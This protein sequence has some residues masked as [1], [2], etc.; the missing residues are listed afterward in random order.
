MLDDVSGTQ[1]TSGMADVEDT[2]KDFWATRPRRPRRGRKIAGVAAGIARRYRIDPTLVR[3]GFVVAAVYGGTGIALYLLGWLFLPEQDDEVSPIESL[4]GKGRS[5]T[6]S[7]FTILLGIVLVPLLGWFFDGGTFG[8]F[9]A[10]LSLLV[11]G[12]LLY[13]LHQ[14]RGHLTPVRTSPPATQEPPVM[15]VMPAMPMTSAPVSDVRADL[16]HTPPVGAP[17]DAPP[18]V[19]DRTTPPAWDPLGA[20]PFAWDLPEP[21]TPPEPEEPPQPPAK[22]HKSR[23][24][25]MTIGLALVVAAGMSFAMGGWITPQHIV[26]VV[27]AV[28]GLGMVAGAFLRG[29]RGLIALAVPLSVAGLA[30]TVISPGGYHGVGDLTAQPTSLAQLDRE[31]ERS[32]GN[33]TLNLTSLPLSDEVIEV[34]ARAD[35]G[36]V[37]VI[38]PRTA[39]V[40][41][42]CEAE[43]GSV[44]CLDREDSG[45][46]VTVDEYESLGSDGAGGQQIEIKAEVN[47]GEVEVRRG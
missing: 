11:I 43:R 13:L 36:N 41:V 29:G 40:V 8:S 18:P 23:I 7:G 4:L 24:G 46:E 30:L 19:D 9:P 14:N 3:V 34:K 28:L 21:S 15:P 2:V 42:T 16:P 5:S 1:Q 38:V 26:G 37:E 35:I 17:V 31:Y 39:D 45:L 6:S 22:R 32:V 27:L 44:A 33:V 10:W 20:A 47:T 12:G 25:T